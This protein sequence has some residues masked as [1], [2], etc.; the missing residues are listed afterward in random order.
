VIRVFL[1]RHGESESNAG[2]PSA[3]PGSAPL[4]PDGHRQAR[5]IARV[6]ADVPALIVTSPYLRA[7]QTAQPTI[8]RF[9]AAGCQEWPVQEF[10]YLAGLHG[11]NST[12]TER[13]PYARAYWDQADPH[14]ASPGA[15]S[16]TGLISRTADFLDRLSAQRSGPVAVFTHGLFMRAVA[17][18]L[19][20]GI[21]TPG[22]DEMRSFR[23]F[24]SSY[25]IPNGGVI[26]LRQAGHD[27]PVLLGGSTIHLPAA[28]TPRPR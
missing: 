9:P 1:I 19:L 23:R 4:T 15:E 11:R 16:F 21:T 3:D 2:L 13:Q 22:H 7:R 25:L 14:H 18:S 5:Q 24:A 6:L 26:E 17:W 28:L 27:A 20:T 10:T 12:A 8:S